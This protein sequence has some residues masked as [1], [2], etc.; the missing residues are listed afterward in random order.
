MAFLTTLNRVKAELRLSGAADDDYLNGLIAD[1][2]DA[3][4][5]WA[6]RTFD[7]A[8]AVDGLRGYGGRFLTLPR[9]PVRAIYAVKLIVLGGA[10]LSLPPTSYQLLDAGLG[11]LVRFDG[12]WDW[13]AARSTGLNRQPR[14]GTELPLWQVDYEGGWTLPGAGG[15]DLPEAIERACL[16]TVKAAWF[17]RLRDPNLTSE[18]ADDL[19]SGSWRQDQPHFLP[20]V[21]RALVPRRF[22]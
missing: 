21:A 18:R 17:A 5:R 9:T 1:A 12:V 16:E 8:R 10:D 4:A 3:L 19:Y 22:G 14:S 13:T 20:P 11:T 2:S 15:R 7:R 6:G